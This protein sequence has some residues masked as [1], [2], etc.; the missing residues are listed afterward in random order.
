MFLF[1]RLSASIK[2]VKG[3]KVLLWG[4]V[5]KPSIQTECCLLNLCQ[6]YYI[7]RLLHEGD[8]LRC[9]RNSVS[10]TY[11][12]T[13]PS[14]SSSA[15][16]IS[17]FVQSLSTFET[18]VREYGT[19]CNILNIGI[20]FWHKKVPAESAGLSAGTYLVVTGLGS[21]SLIGGAYRI[22]AYCGS[23]YFSSLSS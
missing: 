14:A 3:D 5:V 1:S 21:L 2:S 15:P 13:L 7:L 4:G 8:L 6:R 23:R 10:V 22:G 9:F 20:R 16:C 18:N 17:S 11:V 12:S 19:S